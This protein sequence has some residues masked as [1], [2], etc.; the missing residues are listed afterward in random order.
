MT[1]NLNDNFVFDEDSYVSGQT[2]YILPTLSVGTHKLTFR[3]W[4]L[5]NNS[6]TVTLDFRVVKGMRPTIDDVM[7]SPNPIRGTATFYVQ[8]DMR[9]SSATVYIDIIDMSGRVVE[10]LHWDNT[11]SE[12]SVVSAYKWTPSGVSPGLYLYRVRLSADGSEYVS[13]TKKLIIAN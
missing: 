12:T 13:K 2:Y 9:G 10:T 5:L 7:V 3:A 6:S 1:Y 4:D 11:F 8:H